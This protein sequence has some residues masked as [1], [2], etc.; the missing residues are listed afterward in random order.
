MN[1]QETKKKLQW[2]PTLLIVWNLI[3]IIVHVGLNM[4]ETWPI[5]GNIVGIATAL[6]VLLGFAKP[7]ALHILGGQPQRSLSSMVSMLRDTATSLRN[8]PTSSQ[9]W[10][11]LALHSFCC[12]AG[13]RSNGQNQ[14]QRVISQVRHS[15]S[16]GGW[17]SLP[18]WSVL[19]L[20]LSA[21]RK[22][23]LVPQ[24]M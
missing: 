12:C 17:P 6:I 7:F 1:T 13:R 18:R 4:A 15:T 2:L 10:S 5:A 23:I 24:W 16:V 21:A 9:R 3:D 14:V 8:T 11:S 22:S 20:C 19:G